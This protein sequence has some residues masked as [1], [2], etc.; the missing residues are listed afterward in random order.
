M[1]VSDIPQG[2]WWS[3]C[4]AGE[5]NHGWRGWERDY[6]PLYATPME[7]DK[8][9][10]QQDSKSTQTLPHLSFITLPLFIYLS[11]SLS[12][13][14]FLSIFTPIFL[15]LLISFAVHYGKGFNTGLG[16]PR[17]ITHSLCPLTQ[18]NKDSPLPAAVMIKF[19]VTASVLI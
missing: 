14:L 18:V 1:P 15:S 7:K 3:D 9:T 10:Y 4:S 6:Q 11:L 5:I 8:V 13:L 19:T 2:F 12:I 16:H 17:R